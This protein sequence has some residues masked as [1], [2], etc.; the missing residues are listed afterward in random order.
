MMT[1]RQLPSPGAIALTLAVLGLV[2][3]APW[4]ARV[5]LALY[6]APDGNDQWA[7]R[8]ADVGAPDGPF[9]TLTRA[10]DEIRTLKAAGS[11]PR[12]AVVNVL[13]GTYRL[14]EPFT[15]TA[16]DSGT[17]DAPIVYRGVGPEKPRLVG[18]RALKGFKP[19]R[20][21]IVQCDL[22]ANGLAGKRFGQLFFKGT[23]QVLART[24]NR[25]AKDVHG[26]RWAHV[27]RAEGS[28]QHKEF[29]YDT[30]ETHQWAHPQDGRVRIFGGYDWAFRI[31]PIAK[32]VPEEH[33]IVLK[34]Q[35]WGPLRIGDR[36]I[37]EGLLEELDAPGEWHL[38]PR[39]DTLYF[40]P[41]DPLADGDVV[42]PAA[43]S[44]VSLDG[45]DHVTLRGF[46]AEMC[47]GTGIKVKDCHHTLVAGN[48]VRHCGGWG[49]SVSGGQHTGARSND[50]A[51]CGHG[52]I[53][54]H[55]GSRKTLAP[56]HNFA[57]NNHVHHCANIWL[58]Y[59]PGISINGVGNVIRHNL[60]HD[61]PHAGVLL[62]GNDNVM[63]FN[64]VHHVNLEST[65]T[66][67]I[68]FCSRD[69]TQRGNVIRYNLF[70][71]IG[72]FGK[73]NSWAPVRGGKVPFEY[74]HFTWG[75]Y[76]DDPTTGTHVH[77][78][79]LYAVPICGLHN[80]GGRD[81]LWE[82]NVI[83]DCPAFQAGR[84][85]PDWSE[86]PAIYERLRENRYTCSPYLANYPKIADIADTRPEAMTGVRFQRNIIYYTKA[87]TAWLRGERGSSWGGDGCQLLYT[88]HIDQQDFRADFFDHNCIFAE[89]GLDL[90][91]NC[92]LIPEPSGLLTWD[93]WR[94]TGADAHSVLAD[95]LF[96]DAANHDYRLRPDSPALKLGFKPI[97]TDRIGPYRDEFRTEWPIHE[98]PGAAALGDFTTERFY[99]PPRFRRTKAQEAVLRDGLGNVFAK[100][101]AGKP[102]KVA[103]FGGGIHHAGT[104]WRAAVIKWL[105][106]HY[107]NVEEI[108]AGICDCCRGIGFSVYRF[109]HDV[110]AHKPDLIIVEF[111]PTPS[112][113]NA[114][115]IQRSTEAIIRQAWKAD[116]TIDFLFL[117]AFV[118][119]YEEDYAEGVA[120]HP[121]SAYEHVANHYGAM[122]IDMA[123]R[124]AA[125]VRQGKLLPKGSPDEAKKAGKM[126]FSTGGRRPTA[127]AH[128][129]YAQVILAAL[130]QAANSPKAAPHKLPATPFRSDHSE[131]V[132]QVPITRRML[133]GT[134]QAL[135]AGHELSKRFARH[136]D[137]IWFTNTPGSK[138][139]FR[140]RGTA[141]SLFDLMGPDT[142]R[143]KV[144]IDG[145]DAGIRQQV[146]PWSYYQRLSALHLA[147]G[148]SEGIHTVTVELL[149]DP[150]NRTVPI[151]AAKKA[152]QH[153]PKLFEGVALR[154]GSIRIV[155]EPV[156]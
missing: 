65:D 120:P 55:G 10:R 78:N 28:D 87:G 124:I 144:T 126:L 134:W 45:A 35:S 30:D 106:D 119:G 43:S 130:E 102:L 115:A 12:G 14:A 69:W 18:G 37:I 5:P 113:G 3:C 39:T 101:K 68:Y 8:R 93:E 48:T 27:A 24:P 77:G 71:H 53:S 58:T 104:G 29:F 145:K 137:T 112:E 56:G 74:P 51:W 118:A 19:Y 66:G 103:Y 127:E 91:V 133:S 109:G 125:L 54:I 17:P 84:L 25:D 147:S 36:Y 88:L 7:G 129:I 121:V 41:P 80:H 98:A 42:A 154:I 22:K 111:A 46:L 50:V 146:D 13:P 9:A 86:W 60:I 75:I 131:R 70:H 117:H 76:L 94:K 49:I 20:G 64:T 139:T 34:G 90:R 122:S 85:A 40:W 4:R 1:T 132:R 142:G 47:E 136:F 105:R 149:P 148:L 21:K 108:D 151:E 95:P 150:P 83:V 31:V 67:G 153:D 155:G 15:L 99:E 73:A 89:P 138:L 38:D 44:L 16:E 79:I 96:V 143:A 81:N 114:D 110:L 116:P 33:K 59:R 57:D 63:E 52:G 97:P 32:H 26:G 135:P 11:L 82:N 152:G 6:V 107:G 62:G 72:G 123:C 2:S 156:E 23:R 128:R 92:R 100:A 141:T 140:F 61:M